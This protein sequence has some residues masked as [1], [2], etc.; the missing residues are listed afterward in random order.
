M[1]EYIHLIRNEINDSFVENSHA[2]WEFLNYAIHKLKITYQKL[3]PKIATK[4]N[5][6]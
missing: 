1:K 6:I 3:R 2:K 5:Y 4:R